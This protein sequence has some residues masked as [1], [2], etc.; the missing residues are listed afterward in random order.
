MNN[1]QSKL[2]NALRSLSS[3]WS[4]YS[5]PISD[6]KFLEMIHCPLCGP[7]IIRYGLDSGLSHCALCYGK[8]ILPNLEIDLAWP[9]INFGIEVQGGIWKKGKSGHS[10]GTGIQRDILKQQLALRYSWTIVPFSSDDVEVSY[11]LKW[12]A[13]FLAGRFAAAAAANT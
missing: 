13:D 8:G 9:D 3:G 2:Y 1:P 12:I 6:Y 7:S 10:S 5:K 4:R 11:I